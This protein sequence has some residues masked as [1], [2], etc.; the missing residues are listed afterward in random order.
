MARQ[1]EAEMEQKQLKAELEHKAEDFAL[2]TMN[3]IQKN[4]ILQKID[5]DLQRAADYI[6]SDS[7]KTL[8]II[9]KI[10]SGI[11]E[12]IAHD[13]DWQKFETNF[14]MVYDDY[15]K[16]LGAD[17]PTLTHSDKKIC[18]YLR[19]DL[20]S[21]DIAPLMNMT[22]RSVEMTRYRLRKKLNLDR[23]A[24]LTAFLQSY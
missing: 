20:S 8:M 18:A 19:M 3:L 5:S 15:L 4:D 21:K 7:N 17:F 2:S 24:N 13:D 6:V 1:K 10:R 11:R 9:T 12:N 16:R 23:S 22:V 14:D